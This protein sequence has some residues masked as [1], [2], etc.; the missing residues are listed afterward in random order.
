MARD[1]ATEK[2]EHTK[3]PSSSRR[4]PWISLGDNTMMVERSEE[5][6]TKVM[7]AEPEWRDCPAETHV[8]FHDLCPQTP[9]PGCPV[10]DTR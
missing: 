5:V 4:T 6:P 1:P 10:V 9:G 8:E 3:N 2:A 7:I